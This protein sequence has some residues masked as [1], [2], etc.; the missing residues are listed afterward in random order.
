MS[1]WVYLHNTTKSQKEKMVIF[2]KPDQYFYFKKVPK[3][4]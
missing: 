4:F 1:S 3:S 2:L